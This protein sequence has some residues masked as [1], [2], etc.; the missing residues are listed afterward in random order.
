MGRAIRRNPLQAVIVSAILLAAFGTVLVG[1]PFARADFTGCGYGYGPGSGYGY[2]FGYGSCPPSGGGGGGGG[3]PATQ[4]GVAGNNRDETA[5]RASQVAFPTNGSAN[6]VVLARNDNAAD[7]LAGSRMATAVNGPLLITATGQL[8]PEVE[9]EIKRVLPSGGTVFI[10][11]GSFAISVAVEQQLQADGFKTVRA[12]GGTRFETAVAVA[13]AEQQFNGQ[14]TSATANPPIF[15]ATGLNF[16]DGLTAGNAAG[17]VNGVVL[18]S[19]DNQQVAAT[20]SYIK[21]HPNDPL[22]AVGGQAAAAYPN[23]TPL[24]GGDRFETA[25]IVARKFYPNPIKVGI[26]TGF[27]FPDALS[28]GA[29]VAHFGGPLV[30]TAQ[31]ILSAATAQ[32]LKDTKST[33]TTDYIFGGE[34]AI[35]S[36]VRDQIKAAQT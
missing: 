31:D 18:L 2:V 14:P 27:Q 12:M 20:N 1:R 32:Y 8:D 17:A 16:P 3:G 9:A 35:S 24:V 4:T 33:V 10:L 26:A 13:D 25:T 36:H 22:F 15:I 6:A 34:L 5:I 11:G 19:N 23:A 7:A 28:G 29:M 30:L 21:N